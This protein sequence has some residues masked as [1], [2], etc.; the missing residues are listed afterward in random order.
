MAASASAAEA[1]ANAARK[2]S[3]DKWK[4][5]ASEA[6]E[7]GAGKAHRWARLPMSWRP[8]GV[9]LGG[10][11]HAEPAKL[12]E[13][14]AERKAQAWGCMET[15]YVADAGI[16]HQ[17]LQKPT[18]SHMRA[19]ARSF[20]EV[21]ASTFDGV[22]VRH[23]GMLSDQAYEV[24]AILF[25]IVETL[26][27]FP[28]VVSAVHMA[29]LEKAKGGLRGIGLLPAVVRFWMR[30]RRDSARLWESQHS[31][32]FLSAVAGNSVIDNRDCIDTSRF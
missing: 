27:R 23:F 30:V 7:S 19:A 22:H 4:T 16:R 21:V 13:A 12:L 25:L 20:Q 26:G 17:P 10:A 8:S 24:L 31:R 6:A 5:W 9:Q 3:F 32:P 28:H 18:P 11:W 1:E 15:C 29:L 2:D 14:E